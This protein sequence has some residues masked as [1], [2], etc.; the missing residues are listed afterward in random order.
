MRKKRIGSGATLFRATHQS[1][2][3]RNSWKRIFQRA[4]SPSER[5]LTILMK[6][7][8]KPIAAQPIATPRSGE[9]GRRAGAGRGWVCWVGEAGGKPV[10]GPPHRRA[11]GG[12]A[13]RL[14]VGGDGAGPAEPRGLRR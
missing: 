11:E 3:A 1:P 10:R 6:S 9:P 4:E 2:S 14:P 5:R 13:L 7:S 8:A 12:E